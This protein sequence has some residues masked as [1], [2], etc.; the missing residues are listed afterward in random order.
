MSVSRRDRTRGNG[1][2]C[3]TDDPS[4]YLDLNLDELEAMLEDCKARHRALDD[5]IASL[6]GAG[7][8]PFQLMA[9]KREK[10]RLKDRI[11]WIT[12]RLTPDII[13]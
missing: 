13:A 4:E 6:Q 9:L 8:Q 5:E 12:S 2:K 11:V 3:V 1:A 7:E 10:L